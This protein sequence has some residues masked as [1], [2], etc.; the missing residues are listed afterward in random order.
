MWDAAV[1]RAV[2]DWH[3]RHLRLT[4]PQL[5]FW[6]DVRLREFDGRWLAVADLA[7]TPELGMGMTP[8]E[9]LQSALNRLGPTLARQLADRA[10]LA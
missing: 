2:Y 4:H 6:I 7:D 8:S 9:A 5:D 3:L 1:T 10:R